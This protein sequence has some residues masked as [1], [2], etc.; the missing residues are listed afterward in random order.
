MAKLYSSKEKIEDLLKK[1]GFKLEDGSSEILILENFNI[2]VDLKNQLIVYPEDLL[3]HDNSTINFSSE[4][5]FVVLWCVINL[6]KTGYKS[7]NIQLEKKY[8]LG[9]NN[10]GKLDILVT[11]DNGLVYCMIE[12][13]TTKTFYN[14]W[15]NMI[16]KDESKVNQLFSYYQQDKNAKLLILFTT[17]LSELR[18]SFHLIK[19]SDEMNKSK[20]LEETV[21]NWISG[22][23]QSG[24]FDEIPYQTRLD[25]NLVTNQLLEITEE[26]GDEIF[27]LFLE[28]LRRYSISDKPNAF[29]KIFNLFIC[30]IVDENKNENDEL[31]FQIKSDDTSITLL[32]RLNDLYK[33]GMKKF[34][35]KEITDYSDFE[36]S[37]HIN[38]FEKSNRIKQIIDELRLYKSN[39]FSFSEVFNKESFEKNSL[40]VK[41]VVFLLQQYKFRY[42]KK[43]PYLGLFFEKLLGKGFKQESGQFFT[44]IPIVEFIL[45]SIP[46]GDIMKN[47]EDLVPSVLDYACG[48][49][50]FLTGVM[51]EIQ[52]IINKSDWESKSPDIKR[53]IKS[54]KEDPYSWAKDNIYGVELDYR[55]VKT[56]KVSCFLN[57]DGEAN[58][59]NANGLQIFGS[60]EFNYGLL[61]KQEQFDLILANPPYSVSNFRNL[62]KGNGQLEQFYLNRFCTKLSSSIETFFV[63][64]TLQAL[65]EN[66]IFAIIL[67][68]AI[69]K[70]TEDLYKE[71][72]QLLFTRFEIKSITLLKG[73][74]FMATNTNTVIVFGKKNTKEYNRAEKIWNDFLI[75]KNNFDWRGEK[76]IIDFYLKSAYS[77]YDYSDYIKYL[78]LNEEN[79][80]FMEVEKSKLLLFLLNYNS[81]IPI[82][83]S[84]NSKEEQR[85]FLGYYF[86]Q[87]KGKEGIQFLQENMLFDESNLFNSLK[88]NSYILKSFLNIKIEEVNKE[89][90]ELRKINDLF[91]YHSEDF[92]CV[93]LVKKKV[94]IS[95]FPKVKIK[96]IFEF[97]PKSKR[98]ASFANK[99]GSFP[100]FTSSKKVLKCDIADF[101]DEH[102]IIGDGG[103]LSIHISDNFSASDHNFI[104]KNLDESKIKIKYIYYLLRENFEIISQGLGDSDTLNN[105]SKYFLENLELP[106]PNISKQDEVILSIN[107]I[108]DK[109]KNMQLKIKNLKKEIRTEFN[110]SY[111]EAKKAI[112]TELLT[113]IDVGVDKP[114][115]KYF[116]KIKNEY[117]SLPIISNDVKKKISGYTNIKYKNNKNSVTLS[118]RGTIGYAEYRDYLFFP[119]VR[120]I[121]LIPNNKI[122]PKWLYYYFKFNRIEVDSSTISQL[123][124][125][126]IA[127][128]EVLY[129]ELSTQ[130][131]IAK[132]LDEINFKINELK[133]NIIENKEAI[134]Y[135]LLDIGYLE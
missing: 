101:T 73:N 17:D 20:N 14:T 79:K 47:K 82:I 121:T 34:L 32:K 118:A 18:N 123:T 39:E 133:K 26:K 81:E 95:S 97:K 28:I 36:I 125:P 12:C 6:L 129:P 126:Y 106:I 132:T 110:K 48:S 11:D 4:E 35:N 76:N 88:A 122:D 62:L 114:K 116:S 52:T 99:F 24:F 63:E 80:S 27:Y 108:S 59:I 42:A 2:K 77:N 127:N 90:V 50:H 61:K 58:I 67:P 23:I 1:M 71:T 57:G 51:D 66:G 135:I 85:N 74:T 124:K 40:I 130:R 117:F 78:N 5:N 68:V 13:K 3:L 22:S 75:S 102:I 96:E 113:E 33:E 70:N 21:D 128:I 55:L 46:L 89:F 103:K 72:R 31:D 105:I 37:N 119:T 115:G 30:K 44:P 98:P 91:E 43:Q 29:N 83:K 112:I 25:K 107:Q 111:K 87:R 19:V 69:F 93:N 16:N 94:F 54:W 8:I 65:K 109:I 38:D 92:N 100:F 120:L 131:K 64:R 134:K 41:D 45:K 9:R 7:K 10:K 84:G 56:T 15:R 53:K 104:L 86:S 49:G 60:K